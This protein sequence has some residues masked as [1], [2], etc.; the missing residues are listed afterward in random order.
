M[1]SH[2][3]EI[4]AGFAQWQSRAGLQQLGA[5]KGSVSHRAVSYRWPQWMLWQEG[6]CTQCVCVPLLGRLLIPMGRGND[7]GRPVLLPGEHS[8]CCPGKALG[9]QPSLEIRDGTGGSTLSICNPVTVTFVLL[10]AGELNISSHL[11]EELGNHVCYERR[12]M[13]TLRKKEFK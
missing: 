10:T 4:G 5:R 7:E 11:R 6:F 13:M 8:L 2:S 3:S 12:A 1:W 9:D